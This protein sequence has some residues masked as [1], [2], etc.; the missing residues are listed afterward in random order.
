[1]QPEKDGSQ[2][3]YQRTISGDVITSWQ[4]VGSHTAQEWGV[5]G[6]RGP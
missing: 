2:L 6:K 5:S 1:M 3:E 4:V